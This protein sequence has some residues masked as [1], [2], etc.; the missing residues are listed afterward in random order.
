MDACQAQRSCTSNIIPNCLRTQA[1]ALGQQVEMFSLVAPE[2][3]SARQELA[4]GR[5]QVTSKEAEACRPLLAP[6]AET[7]QPSKG[8]R[9]G[10]EQ[11]RSALADAMVAVSM[12]AQQQP[13]RLATLLTFCSAAL[14][15]TF[16][17]LEEAGN[18][19]ATVEDA[20]QV[21]AGLHEVVRTVIAHGR[22]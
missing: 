11:Q 5:W 16:P 17:R 12:A 18:E 7:I 15:P 3:A 9:G 1:T 14:A 22:S 6:L 19:R 21:L 20:R 4:D 8:G 2:L 10:G 13:G